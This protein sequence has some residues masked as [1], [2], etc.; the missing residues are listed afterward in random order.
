V[1][2]LVLPL[3]ALAAL[4]AEA[5][6]VRWE[7]KDAWAGGRHQRTAVV[8]G[9][10]VLA[11]G[12]AQGT[13]TASLAGEA[14]DR[15]LVSLNHEPWPATSFVRT[16]VRVRTT[17]G[18]TGWLATGDYGA[19]DDLP[20]SVKGTATLGVAVKTDVL[21]ANAPAREAELRLELWRGAD[22]PRVR[23]LACDRWL[24]ATPPVASGKSPAWGTVLDVP[25]RTQHVQDA[26]LAARICSP[27]SLSMVL[28]FHGRALDTTAVAHRVWDRAADLYGNWS[29]NVSYASSLGFEAT[30]AHL[31]GFAAVEA[32][33]AAGR[34]VVISHRYRKGDLST[35][36]DRESDGHLVVVVG[37]TESG[38]VV[39]NDPAGGHPTRTK[40]TPIRRVFKRADVLRT[41][42][43]R[44]DGVA[45]LLRPLGKKQ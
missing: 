42:Q 17:E 45:Y 32:E 1:R 37:F 13:W 36:P 5:Q 14:F 29:F 3:L 27:T 25:Q 41:W 23:R 33:I 24:R 11:D 18:W 7:A 15:L 19:G 44:G 10:L 40:P 26:A 21:Q 38:D 31:D 28:A 43:Q 39:V 16:F 22:S 2:A 12:E 30:A 35:E 34:P 6:T 8:D 20:R 4:S 9:R